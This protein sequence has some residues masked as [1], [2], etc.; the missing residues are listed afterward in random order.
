MQIKKSSLTKQR[1]LPVEFYFYSH[2]SHKL[3]QKT[4]EKI[5]KYN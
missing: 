2:I 4:A 1:R 3:L 5:L